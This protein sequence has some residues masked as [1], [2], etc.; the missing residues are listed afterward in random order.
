MRDTSHPLVQELR[1]VHE[2]LRRDLRACR[3]LAADAV[4]GAP[5]ATLRET[6]DQFAS[7][8]LLFQL[9]ARCLGYCRLV[10]A[11]HSG[12]DG[13]L[14]PVVRRS[15][16]QLGAVLDRL[17]ADHRVVSDILD[18]IEA[19]AQRLDDTAAPAIRTRLVDA[20]GGLSD[21]LLEHLDVEERALVPVLLT[22]ERW[23]EEVSSPRAVS[24]SGPAR[25]GDEDVDPYERTSGIAPD[26]AAEID[27]T[28]ARIAS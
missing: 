15:A 25:L 19:A 1:R 8:S 6:V 16:P 28:V 4:A 18:D 26:A 21:H 7:R 23:P 2:M 13:L 10:H 17:Q 11:H 5:P 24:R 14:F 20:L 3:E 27:S 12:E 22:W 9:R